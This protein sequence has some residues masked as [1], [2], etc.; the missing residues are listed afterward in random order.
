MKDNKFIIIALIFVL[1]LGG[2]LAYGYYQKATF[3]ITRPLVS[4][5]IEG[6]GTVKMEL[7]PNIA[8]ETVKNFI[9]LAKSGFYDGLIFHRVIPDFMAQGGDPDG[10]GTITFNVQSLE[11]EPSSSA[12]VIVSGAVNQSKR[13][14]GE[15]LLYFKIP[16]TIPVE[17]TKTFSFTVTIKEDGCP[18]YTRTIS[19]TI[20]HYD[21]Q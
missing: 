7:Y 14:N 20:K 19:R 3:K 4:M 8:P 16:V 1:I 5:E 2:F 13:F 15:E 17:S 21:L 6:Y 9:L 11:S 18:S 10:N 12:K